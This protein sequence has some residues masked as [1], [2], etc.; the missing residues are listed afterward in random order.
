MKEKQKNLFLILATLMCV[1]AFICGSMMMKYKTHAEESVVNN[2][3]ALSVGTGDTAADYSLDFA[4]ETGASVRISSPTGIRFRSYI[5]T[6][7]LN[8]LKDKYTDVSLGTVIVPEDYVTNST[9]ITIETLKNNNILYADI[10]A[11]NTYQEGERTYYNAALVNI[12]Y[13]NYHRGFCARSYVKVTVSGVD[14]YGY[15]DYSAENNCRSVNHVAKMALN[16]GEPQT[17]ILKAFAGQDW[18]I[19][20]TESSAI[21]N[22][23]ATVDLSQYYTIT[24]G[25]DQK[26]VTVTATAVKGTVSGL[27]YTAPS[28]DG[29]D[30]VTFTAEKDGVSDTWELQVTIPKEVQ[31]SGHTGMRSGETQTL[32]ITGNFDG[33]DKGTWSSNSANLSVD[34][35][36]MVTALSEGNG[37]I[38]Y[39]VGEIQQQFTIDIIGKDVAVPLTL[40][41][42]AQYIKTTDARSISIVTSGTEKLLELKLGAAWLFR[43]SFTNVAELSEETVN[44]VKFYINIDKCGYTYDK[45]QLFYFTSSIDDRVAIVNELHEGKNSVTLP[46]ALF[47]QLIRG[48]KKLALVD[49][50]NNFSGKPLKIQLSDVMIVNNPTFG[51]QGV[52]PKDRVSLQFDEQYCYGN[53]D[54]SFKLDPGEWDMQFTLTGN[55]T[56][57]VSFYVYADTA[58]ATELWCDAN[59]TRILVLQPKTWTKVQLTKEQV[60]AIVSGTKKLQIRGNNNIS[61]IDFYVSNIVE[62]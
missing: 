53:E 8:S 33:Y 39:T 54:Y 29:K 51:I 48:E 16:A 35:S 9:E 3:V 31:I 28:K 26:D 32:S 25:V 6:A 34:N 58:S 7:D 50:Q 59:K 23:G 37:T 46:V 17:D 11:E 49:F 42:G 43:F 10:V 18:S 5:K 61:A 30:T 56:K 40:E 24:K 60:D 36:G 62:E 1:F 47:N 57:G 20:K 41:S 44:C 27:T 13:Y 52:R 12:N 45:I 19:T 22:T 15:T 38:V 14:Y 21:I 55:Y 2:K 4:M